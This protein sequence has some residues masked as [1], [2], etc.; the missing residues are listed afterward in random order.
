MTRLGVDSGKIR[1]SFL[2][3]KDG[4][5]GGDQERQGGTETQPPELTVANWGSAVGTGGPVHEV[6]GRKN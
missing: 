1:L 2:L 5:E 6:L 3:V 4:L